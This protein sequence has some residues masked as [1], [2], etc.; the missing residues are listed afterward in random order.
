MEQTIHRLPQTDEERLLQYG[1]RDV[2]RELPD[3]K[4]VVER[5]PLTLE[6]LLHPQVG[7]VAVI[8]SLHDVERDYLSALFRARLAPISGALVLADCK[9]D[10]EGDTEGMT[11][12]AP[13]ICVIKDVEERRTNWTSFNV[14]EQ[15]TRPSLIIEIVSPSY[16]SLDTVTKV[17]H[18]LRCKVPCYVIV[19][20]EDVYDVPKLIGRV[21]RGNA[22]RPLLPNDRGLLWLEAVGV[23]LGVDGDRI[24]CYEP[25]TLKPIGDYGEIV[26][27]LTL[28]KAQV[29]AE[30]QFRE[31]A[32]AKA[33]QAEISRQ[34]EA[35]ARLAAEA[36]VAELEAKMQALQST[37]PPT[38]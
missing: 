28:Q 33:E 34:S 31:R 18:Y 10:W 5:L 25:S 29:I 1:Y 20:R 37:N 36:R 11:Y 35:E 8:S 12:H 26:G 24:R 21:R 4:L 13:D 17:E 7:D 30:R 22:W 14:A 6:D 32:E 23:Y 19:D 15:G 2:Y 3:G 16:R 27:E 38:P 9:L